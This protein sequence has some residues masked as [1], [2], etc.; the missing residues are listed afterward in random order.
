MSYI[1][2]V[3]VQLRKY[4]LI[5]KLLKCKFFRQEVNFLGYYVSVVGVS[6]DPSRVEAIQEWP[7]PKSFRDIQ[8]FLG[9]TNFYHGFIYRY[10]AIIAPITNLLKGIKNGK[11]TSL[12]KQTK[13][14]SNTFRVLKAYFL[15]TPIVVYFKYERLI[16]VEVDASRSSLGGILLQVQEAQGESTRLIQKLV[17]FYLRK[18]N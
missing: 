2:Q 5:A 11:K 13:D 1:R 7:I 18:I 15:T 10:S 8:V 12:F 17:A 3:L 9:F 16:K 4:R 14:A 6:I